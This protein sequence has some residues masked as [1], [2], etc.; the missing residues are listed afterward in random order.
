MKRIAFASIALIAL[1][2]AVSAQT[3]ALSSN[4]KV[5]L[6]TLAPDANLDNLSVIQVREINRAVVSNDG[7]SQYEL[8]TIL[9]N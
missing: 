5:T 1:T 3:T 6:S 9:A 8:Q 4:A 7:L 2:G